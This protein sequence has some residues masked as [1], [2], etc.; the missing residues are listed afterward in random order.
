MINRRDHD[1]QTK[2]KKS[3]LYLSEKFNLKINFQMRT[4]L[5]EY[6]NLINTLQH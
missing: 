5:S 6:Q 2:I 1:V 4:V 3:V